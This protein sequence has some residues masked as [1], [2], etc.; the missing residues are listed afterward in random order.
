[1]NEKGAL[2]LSREPSIH[3]AFYDIR[4]PRKISLD[5]R[6]GARDTDHLDKRHTTTSS[7]K[8]KQM[9]EGSV[10]A[11]KGSMHDQIETVMK[12]AGD[13]YDVNTMLNEEISNAPSLPNES[14]AISHADASWLNEPNPVLET[15]EHDKINVDAVKRAIST[16][17]AR[18]RD[19]KDKAHIL[20]RLCKRWIGELEVEYPLMKRDSVSRSGIHSPAKSPS[21]SSKTKS[22]MPKKKTPTDPQGPAKSSKIRY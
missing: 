16:L 1:M 2:E 13:L 14:P 5:P 6:A 21:K 20:A 4:E 18:I 8:N 17:K 11:Q 19:H 3:Q 22:P 12:L 10:V 15:R 9:T 7:A